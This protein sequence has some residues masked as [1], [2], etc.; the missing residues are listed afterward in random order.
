MAANYSHLAAESVKKRIAALPSLGPVAP[1]KVASLTAER[2][3][4]RQ[5]QQIGKQGVT[6]NG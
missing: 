3:N 6:G 2:A 1:S 4:R 5:R